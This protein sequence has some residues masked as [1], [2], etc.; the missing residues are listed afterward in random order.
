MLVDNCLHSL[1][2]I[3]AIRNSLVRLDSKQAG[4]LCLRKRQRKERL[5][6][7]HIHN[8]CSIS[9]YVVI[10]EHLVCTYAKIEQTHDYV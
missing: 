5:A 10:E 1:H 3:H 9:L 4:M 8:V 7:P 2:I 6:V